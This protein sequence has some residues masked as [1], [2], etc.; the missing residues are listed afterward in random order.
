MLRANVVNT[1]AARSYAG[2]AKLMPFGW[3]AYPVVPGHEV[4]GVVAAVGANVKHRTVGQR[5]GVGWSCGA[6][7]HCEYCGRGKE[8]FCAE[9]KFT[10]VGHH[11]GWASAVRS[12]WKHA[13]PIPEALD[14]AEAAPLL[15]AGTTVF[16][17]LSHF[18]VTAKMRTAVIGIGGL[19]HLA[20]QFLSAFGC[21]VAAI[22]SSHSKDE[23]A[24][25]MGASQFIAT[26]SDEELAKA[27]GSFDFILSTVSADVNWAAIVA[28]LRPEGRLAIVG[29]PDSDLKIAAMSLS[30]AR[31]AS[32]AAAAAARATSRKC[33][34]SPP[35]TASR[36]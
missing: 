6:C 19:G 22:S 14:S 27:K 20:L 29:V 7:G 15:C 34:N 33:W 30:A 11:G 17:P 13:I 4:I 8:F 36:R 31:R 18:G 21:E 16:T 12:H 28:A 3:S 10:I 24:R 25:K 1:V 26:K 5:V 32:P 35:S 2:S 9:E 23:E